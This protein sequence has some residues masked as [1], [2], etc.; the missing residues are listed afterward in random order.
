MT[1][2]QAAAIIGC[3]PSHV[4]ALCRNGRISA[5][6]EREEHPN[7]DGTPRYFYWITKTE[8]ERF[9]DTPGRTT[10]GKKHNA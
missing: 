3:T 10:R 1:P 2:T 9:R 6:M 4:R 5:K 7:G 8:V